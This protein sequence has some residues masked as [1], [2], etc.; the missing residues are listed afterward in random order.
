MSTI[1]MIMPTIIMIVTTIMMIV[2]TIMMIVEGII[3]RE[4]NA[5]V[6]EMKIIKRKLYI[7][8]L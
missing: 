2:T 4:T 8:K 7:Y 5:S 1:F 6:N 3:K